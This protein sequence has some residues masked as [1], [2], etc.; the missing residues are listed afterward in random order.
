MHVQLRNQSPAQLTVPADVRANGRC[1]I[2][3]IATTRFMASF[4]YGVS[5]LDPGSFAGAAA[6]LTATALLAAYIPAGRAARVD[7]AVTLRHE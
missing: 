6:F 7:P 3:A 2:A 1:F 5:P 4:L